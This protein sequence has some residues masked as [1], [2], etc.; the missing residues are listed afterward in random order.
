MARCRLCGG[1]LVDNRC[2]ECGLD[3]SQSDSQYVTH[4]TDCHDG[5]L[6]HV[7]TGK[8]SYIA[9]KTLTKEQQEELKNAIRER[10]NTSNSRTYQKTVGTA[11][12]SRYS[13]PKYKRTDSSGQDPESRASLAKAI[14]AFVILIVILSIVELF[15]G[16]AHLILH[17]IVGVF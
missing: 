16:V 15:G 3:N 2:V 9:G 13:D 7:H 12:H 5:P 11:S 8:S 6:T 17:Y 1:K 4:E 10:R 14:K